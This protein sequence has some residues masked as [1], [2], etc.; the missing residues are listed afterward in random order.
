VTLQVHFFPLGFL[1]WWL[2]WLQCNQL[3]AM[4]GLGANHSCATG[5]NVPTASAHRLQRR[6]R[7]ITQPYPNL[8]VFF[9]HPFSYGL[10]LLLWCFFRCIC[11]ILATYLVSTC[12][13]SVFWLSI[14]TLVPHR[15][16][17]MASI[18]H[19]VAEGHN[20]HT[21]SYRPTDHIC[22]PHPYMSRPP[23]SWERAPILS[24]RWVYRS[25]FFFILTVM[26]AQISIT[27]SRLPSLWRLHWKLGRLSI[28]WTSFMMVNHW[29]SVQTAAMA[30]WTR[31]QIQT[32]TWTWAATVMR[33]V[34]QLNPGYSLPM[35]GC[36]YKTG[37]YCIS[38][39]QSF[40]L[41]KVTAARWNTIVTNGHE[42]H[43]TPICMLHG[44]CSCLHWQ[45]HISL[46]SITVCSMLLKLQ[47]T[48]S[49]SQRCM[50]LV[51]F[52]KWKILLLTFS[53]TRLFS[54]YHTT[55]RRSRKCVSIACGSTWLL[56]YC[57]DC[58]N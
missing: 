1:R 10:A 14:L 3:L 36:N 57:T 29:C 25:V 33:A 45:M 4:C 39:T 52:F 43:A 15:Y 31:T 30:T 38:S 46:G 22:K 20:D 41:I 58:C 12:V 19:N 18:P 27:H 54:W 7:Y 23:A 16:G 5:A 42:K 13:P 17:E 6:A 50:S 40:W 34:T 48:S 53:R 51:R 55:A 32:R 26:Y 24:S 35:L 28:Q 11:L 56:S 8:S 47:L 21:S 9:A 44:T 2:S 37:T 49:R